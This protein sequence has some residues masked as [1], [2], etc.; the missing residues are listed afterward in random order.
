VNQN[1]PNSFP[2]S[3]NITFYGIILPQNPFNNPQACTRITLQPNLLSYKC[4]ISHICPMPKSR[5]TRE[6]SS[7][8][9]QKGIHSHPTIEVACNIYI[10]IYI[11]IKHPYF[12]NNVISRLLKNPLI[13]HHFH[14]QPSL[15]TR[16][17]LPQCNEISEITMY[18]ISILL[19]NIRWM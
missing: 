12:C 3:T 18:T 14:Q 6:F 9:T 4:I 5:P 17:L 16:T 8:S 7:W 13:L 10:Y 2:S 11:Y 15:I 19:I 1:S